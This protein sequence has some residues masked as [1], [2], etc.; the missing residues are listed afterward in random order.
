MLNHDEVAR[1]LRA[2]QASEVHQRLDALQPDATGAV[3]RSIAHWR[4]YALLHEKRYSE[5]MSHLE[6][7]ENDYGC[8]S[9]VHH[10]KASILD[11]LGRQREA[12]AELRAAPLSSELESFPELVTDASFYLA[13]LMAKNGEVL[14]DF[15][16]SK[17]PD[18]YISVL[19]AR[20]Q[21]YGAKVSKADIAALLST[22]RKDTRD[23]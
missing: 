1:L 22:G 20:G 15:E 6:A 18:D 5:A 13:Y 3:R 23:R 7:S 21:L 10:E 19:P 4:T 2:G 11:V 14:P 12:I 16:L 9:L 17:I 8:R